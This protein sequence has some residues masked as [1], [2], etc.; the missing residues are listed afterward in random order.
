MIISFVRVH[1][2]QKGVHILGG[3]TT[4]GNGRG[5]FSAFHSRFFKDEGFFLRHDERGV[6]SMANCGKDRNASQF[7]ITLSP[8]PHL[9]KCAFGI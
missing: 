4:N 9:G 8:Q 1:S 7:I 2:I 5:G 6:I 3:D